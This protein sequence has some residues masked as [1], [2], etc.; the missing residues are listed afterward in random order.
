MRYQPR[1]SM[2]FNRLSVKPKVTVPALQSALRP[3][4]ALARFALIDFGQETLY[5]VK[6]QE[7]RHLQN[8][9]LDVFDEQIIRST[10]RQSA[11][12]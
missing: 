11:S 8:P 12:R 7:A 1:Y 4:P 3:R 2:S 10:D 6:H 9:I 5:P